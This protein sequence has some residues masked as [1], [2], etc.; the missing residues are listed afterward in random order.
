MVM[1]RQLMVI[2]SDG[3]TERYLYTKIIGTISKALAD[4]GCADVY[5]AEQ[6]AEA[7]T[8]Y[9]YNQ[10]NS[11]NVTSGEILSIIKAVLTSTGNE[12]AAVALSEYQLSRRLKRNRIEVVLADTQELADAAALGDSDSDHNKVSWDKSQI[13]ENLVSKRGLERQM[14]RAIAAMVEE[15]VFSMGLSSVPVGLIKQLVLSQM[16]VT[17]RAEQQLQAV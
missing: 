9:L 2:K 3:S 10:Q 1:R 17:L 7:V 4:A 13:V 5:L 11:H 8:Y 15:T 14:A 6:L 16:A 12:A